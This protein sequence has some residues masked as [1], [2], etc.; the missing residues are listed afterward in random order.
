MSRIGKWTGLAILIAA[1]GG[2]GTAWGQTGGFTG[3]VTLQDGTTCVKCIVVLERQSVKGVYQ[4]KT[5]KKGNYVYVG[6]PLD[7]Y[8]ITLQDPDGK[9]LFFFNGRRAEMG[10]PTQMDFNLPKEMAQQQK[11]NESNP[12]VQQQKA[13]EEK[14]Q[15]EFTSLKQV[16]EQGQALDSQKQYA[17]AA[18]M[19]QK[20]EPMAKGKNLGVLMEHEAV[21]YQ[22]AKMYDQAVAIYQKLI[23]AD[24]ANPTYH[25][26]LG[27][28]YAMM[29]KPAD[30]EAECAKA[31][32]TAPADGSKCYFNLGAVAHNAG[33]MDDAASAFKKVTELDP[34]NADAFF[35]EGQALMGK[36]TMGADGKVVPAP[37]TVE[38][39][40][41]YLQLQPSGP[42]APEAQGMLQSLTGQVQTEFKSA[43]KKKSS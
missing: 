9:T 35:L 2:A 29:G 18:A 34:K 16:F 15:K 41:A 43:K 21:S 28:S 11:T 22:N 31:A 3:H 4:V 26:D 27:T 13:Q 17:E 30:A 24:P 23:T 37:G 38:A 14:Q 8:K 19:Y 12:A 7:T 36:A 25:S 5:D 40:Q 10:E 1:C 39:L 6:L 20:A 32:Q 42:H 33:R